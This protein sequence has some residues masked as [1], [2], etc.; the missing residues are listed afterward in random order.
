M[1][2]SPKP[3]NDADAKVKAKEQA[4][5]RVTD[6]DLYRHSSQYRVWSFTPE[7]LTQKRAEINARATAKIEQGLRAF[8]ETHPDLTSEELAAIDEKAVPVSTDEELLLVS[9]FARMILSF[10]GKMNLPTEVAATAV[11]FFRKF[12]LSNSV[13]EISP[14]EVFHTA[15]FFSCKSENYFIGVESFAK[16]AKTNPNAVLKHE[17]K[18][19]ESLSFTLMN[20]HPYKALHGFFLDIQSVLAGKVDMNYMGQVY[21]DCKKIITDALLTDAVYFYSP[22]QITLAA[23]LIADEALTM[24]YLQLKF[25]IT[26]E[27]PTENAQGEKQEPKEGTSIPVPGQKLLEVIK[28]CKAIISNKVAPPKEEAV[29]VTAKIHYSQ[30]P[31]TVLDRLKRQRESNSTATTPGQTPVPEENQAKRQKSDGTTD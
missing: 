26:E 5:L 19:L 16:K 6:D 3:S 14:K 25:M 15:L 30:N 10:A 2:S 7:Q 8:R 23:L 9:Y 17:F 27:S 18:L 28:E 31:L 21:T 13:S 24:R 20:H 22:P 12:Y 11:S 4:S 1:S 29:K